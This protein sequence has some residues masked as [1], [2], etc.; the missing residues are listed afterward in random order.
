MPRYPLAVGLV[1]TLCAGAAGFAPLVVRAQEPATP[2]AQTDGYATLVEATPGLAAYW[3][4]DEASGATAADRSGEGNDADYGPGVALDEPGLIGAANAAV[5]L[6]GTADAYLDA[7]DVLDFAAGAPFTLE[8]W[9]QPDEFATPYPRL[10]MKE[11][12]DEAGNRQGYL[13]YISKETGRLGFERWRDGE[14]NVVTTIDPIPLGEVTHV[15]AIYDGQ[16]MRLYIDGE[17]VAEVPAGLGL[18][19]TPFPFRIGARADSGS[20]FAGVVDEVA[21]YQT[22]LTAETI[23]DHFRAGSAGRPGTAI[24]AIV[25]SAATPAIAIAADRNQPTPAD[26][27]PTAETEEGA[28]RAVTIATAAP[29]AAI[30]TAG[31]LATVRPTPTESAAE[32]GE[33]GTAVTT[34]VLNLRASPGTDAEILLII[35]AGEEVVLTGEESAGF[36]AVEYAGA[37]GWVSADFLDLAA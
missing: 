19:D 35:P 4:L 20:P 23:R 6:D 33:T 3:R 30:A 10:L 37:A 25:P 36:V 28:G 32:G 17:G 5:A 2:S 18:S 1:A 13:L 14:A 24:P 31:P 15:V 29:P 21:V 16:A 9:I 7:G 27:T 22:A 8:A 26:E 11:A 34:D 12:T